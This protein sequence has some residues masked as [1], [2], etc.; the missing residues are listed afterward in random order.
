MS[1]DH[2]KT[3]GGNHYLY[4]VTGVWDPEK[5]NSRQVRDMSY[6]A[7]PKAIPSNRGRG[8]LSP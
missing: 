6:P 7:I 3:V 8:M 5:K 4:R 2:I 1:Y